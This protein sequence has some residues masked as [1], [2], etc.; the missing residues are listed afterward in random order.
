MTGATLFSWRFW[1]CLFSVCLQ[2]N[3]EQDAGENEWIYPYSLPA[4]ASPS[5]S[6]SSPPTLILAQGTALWWLACRFVFHPCPFFIS[7][8]RFSV[9]FCE[10][11]YLSSLIFVFFS[12]PS[13]QTEAAWLPAAAIDFSLAMG[14]KPRLRA[15]P[16]SGKSN[17]VHTWIPN[18]YFWSQTS[19]GFHGSVSLFTFLLYHHLH[20][21]SHHYFY[22]LWP[23]HF[24]TS[25]IFI[26]TYVPSI[27]LGN[28][29]FVLVLLSHFRTRETP[30]VCREIVSRLLSSFYSFCPPSLPAPTPPHPTPPCALASLCWRT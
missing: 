24:L 3:S 21:P 15:L 22:G 29:N 23:L 18:L 8:R 11:L 14:L 6:P 10:M 1:N 12:Y 7:S 30:R 20:H 28:V 26:L 2:D 17:F 9:S 13:E 27:P 16:Q 4:T 19:I 5:P 25:D